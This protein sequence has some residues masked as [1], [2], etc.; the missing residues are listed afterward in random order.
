MQE[1]YFIPKE[2]ETHTHLSTTDKKKKTKPHQTNY[3]LYADNSKR[4]TQNNIFILQSGC[5][6]KNKD[7]RI[8]VIYNN[9]MGLIKM[10]LFLPYR[11]DTSY[12]LS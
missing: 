12:F 11:L 3:K 8:Q 1:K 10:M 9:N 6:Q 7:F 4:L 5:L 2:T